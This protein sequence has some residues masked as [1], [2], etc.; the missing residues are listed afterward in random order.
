MTVTTARRESIITLNFGKLT[1]MSPDHHH[2]LANG[3]NYGASD[4]I[5]ASEG[6]TRQIFVRVFLSYASYGEMSRALLH[7]SGKRGRA[8][9]IRSRVCIFVVSSA[10]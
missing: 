4:P 3:E 1:Y 9:K 8:K 6:D 10:S 5:C 7:H 2:K